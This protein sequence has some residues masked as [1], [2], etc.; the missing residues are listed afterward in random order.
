V[1]Q[2]I[3]A[4]VLAAS[5][6]A[7]PVAYAQTGAVP[8][9]DPSDTLKLWSS[10]AFSIEFI[11]QDAMSAAG[12][13]TSTMQHLTSVLTAPPSCS[14]SAS[15]TSITT[16]GQSVTLSYSSSAHTYSL[17]SC[18]ISPTVG[19]VTC[20]T[21]SNTSVSPTTLTTYTLTATDAYGNTCTAHAT[22]FFNP[23]Q[24]A[25]PSFDEFW[26]GFFKNR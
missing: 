11:A 19:S 3:L 9:G 10:I 7:V 12:Q 4:A 20:N 22:V 25:R 24:V 1:K 5:L 21:S 2:S 26:G 8:I 15:P 6:L 23:Q 16:S 14:L 13:L 17:S 18:S